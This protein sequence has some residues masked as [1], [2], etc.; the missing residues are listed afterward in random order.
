MDIA[1]KLKRAVATVAAGALF[2]S[3]AGV[4]LAQTFND[5]SPDA[6]YYDFVEQLVSDGVV[7]VN[8]NFRPADALNRAELVKMAIVSID[9]LAGYE[10]PATPT[11]DDVP[12]DAWFFDYVEA[13]VQLGIVSGYKDAG[14]NLTG[15]FGPGDTVNRAQASKIIVNTY[16]VPTDLDPGSAFPDVNSGDWFH[17]YVVTAYNQSVLD[18]YD[19]GYFGPADPVT[20]AQIAKLIVNGQNPV[21]RDGSGTT[22]PPVD[23]PPGTG[24]LEVSLSNSTAASSTLPLGAASVSL[25]SYDLTA[26]SDDVVVT[27][28]V[29]TRGG[30]GQTE[31]WSALYIYEGAQRL[32]TGRTINSDTNTATFPLKDFV[33]GAGSTRSITVVGDVDLAAGS[34]DQHYF[35]VASAA[36][37]TSNAAS[38]SGD[39][40]V[41]GNTFTMGGA[42][43][44]VNTV[45]VE[46]GSAPAQPVLGE[47]DAEIASIRIQAGST[48]D[49]AVHQI[50]LTQG[51]SLSS[52][53]M[54]NLTLLRGTDVVATAAGFV[55][56][57]VTFVLD[58]P[59]VIPEGQTKTFYVHAD[60]TG[61]RSGD[62]V[63]LYLDENTD[64]VAIDQQ[65]G[66]GA[67]IDNQ[68][69][70]GN[71][72]ALKGGD[73]TVADNGP[74]ATQLAQNSTNNQL[75][76]FAITTAR[77]LTVRDTYIAIEIEDTSA[78]APTPGSAA[79][80]TID[81]GGWFADSIEVLDSSGF[82]AGD[83]V[84]VE[85][86]SG[87][88]YG[89]VTNVP[90]AWT[91][92]TNLSDTEEVVAGGDVVEVDPYDY[93]KNV[94][95][96]DIDSD[97]TLA[98]PSTTALASKV[99]SED[100]ELVGGET[101]HLSVQADLDQN[102][103]AGYRIT[104][105]V[106]LADAVLA[107]I[108]SYVKDLSANEFVLKAD[109]VGA[110][111]TALVGNAMTTARN[112]LLVARASTPTSQT[113][114]KG[115]DAVPS[116]GVSMTAGDAGD[117]T[118]KRLTVRLYVNDAAGT[119]VDELGNTAANQVVS[120]VTLYDGS[121][122]VAGPK[123]ISLVSNDL[124]Y[125]PGTD[126]YKAQFDSLNVVIP[127][128]ES[129]T[130]IA[131]VNLLNSANADRFLALDVSPEADIIAE[132]T[133]ANTITANG[134]DLNADFD[135]TP[136]IT[137]ITAGD[138]TAS[139]ESNPVSD[140]VVAGASAVPVA[141]YRFHALRED[142]VVNKVT[143]VN[144]VLD[145][146]ETPLPNA[147]ITNVVLKYKDSTGADRTKK[148][149]LTSG[150]STL[151]GLDLF[152]PKGG[153]AYLEVSAD[154]STM[155]AV[156]ETLSGQ[157]IRLGLQNV[158]NTVSTFEA[159]GQ[160]SS[161]AEYFDNDGLMGIEPAISGSD[162]VNDFVVRKSVPTF[163]QLSAAQGSLGAGT[164]ALYRIQ[165]T[166]DSAGG[167][168]IGRLL[169]TV[170]PSGGVTVGTYSVLKN[171]A[172][173]TLGSDVEIDDTDAPYVI[174][175]FL[176][177]FT[178]Q[179]GT[180]ATVTLRGEAAGN[181][182]N[183]SISTRLVDDDEDQEV[184]G[185]TDETN[186]NTAE[187]IDGTAT[188]GLFPDLTGL[189][190][191]N[192]NDAG[193]EY[194]N[195]VWSDQSADSHLFKTDDT[196][197][198]DW[199]NGYRLGVVNLDPTALS[200]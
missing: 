111:D 89:I 158:D 163:T 62:T 143:I 172:S 148:A 21:E 182:G 26:A 123:S 179:A 19:N 69:L 120:S 121:D 73:V 34:S 126:F 58:T 131:K 141:K 138:L 180:S 70:S 151:A 200:D 71:T 36:D 153:D 196:G 181:D 109:I 169:F 140:I 17:D 178:V 94:R 60:L 184:T 116:L 44:I 154:V 108:Y 39:F 187:L 128:G 146:F 192:P 25:A 91:I 9:G 142:F 33:V 165:I 27:Q 37:V 78:N 13:A 6:W 85:A 55:G 173:Q 80:T 130:F 162:T 168:S 93:I 83:M 175:T 160:S 1:L 106:R 170:E 49:V 137:I 98:G 125:T 96:V 189:E 113:Y 144:D 2:A 8:D 11:F 147:A 174:V 186:E 31:D 81:G 157:K 12:A 132:D 122:V 155:A 150:K 134:D 65:Y 40:P 7:D 18:G 164:N 194:L 77:D 103:A 76:N 84:Q 145:D 63:R 24:A 74:A 68:M 124:T 15:F 75:L 112:S 5:V 97:V 59:Y 129:K 99:F 117:V 101:R 183:D 90:N 185:K 35:Y 193:Y 66:F 139:S 48:N 171:G 118:V 46:P 38:V 53:K 43:T 82:L 159:I 57:V 167:V 119:W 127:A 28:I 92:E 72:V 64:V 115:D 52:D 95:L 152:V 195:V 3:S 100:Y 197:S 86:V 166:A 149:A 29:V 156:G 45:T 198:Y 67:Q 54:E 188:A 105:S 4:A 51:G 47:L 32:T 23:V 199:T 30:V 177:E 41:A 56:D 102:M 14:G 61:G 87:T 176:K 10:A 22:E 42:T 107:N 136:L 161:S 50:A 20:R 104:A 79:S 191:L 190:Q 88:L 114:V 135:K 133:D 16:S 110:G